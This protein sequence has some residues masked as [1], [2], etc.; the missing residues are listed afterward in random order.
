[1]KEVSA[2]SIGLF[3]CRG[4]EDDQSVLDMDALAHEFAG[5]GSVQVHDHLCLTTAQRQL[6]GS[7]QS[8]E[9][10]GVV[11]ATCS[12]GHYGNSLRRITVERLR[13]AGLNRN[14]IGFANL[15]EQVVLPHRNDPEG[16]LRKARVLIQTALERVRQSHVMEATEIAPRRSVLVIGATIGGILA[17]YRLVAKGYKVCLIDE[18]ER[19]E[20]LSKLPVE[21]LPIASLDDASRMTFCFG[22]GLADSNGW[23]GD[24]AVEIRNVQ[25]KRT[26]N[27]GAVIVAIGEDENPDLTR[28]IH[29]LLLVELGMD[30]QL[31]PLN[32][33]NLFTETREPGVFLV[34]HEE[35]DDATRMRTAAMRA[36]SAT[37]ALAALLD[38]P[39]LYHDIAITEVN[40]DLCGACG[41][42]V[43]TCAFHA[44]S[45]NTALDVATVDVRRCKAC[46][47][48][49]TACPAA[50]R[51]LITYPHHYITRAIETLAGYQRCNG[52]PKVLCLL[53]DSC[54]YPA[55]DDA[56]M[57]GCEYPAS[58]LPLNI[59]CGGRVDT[60]YLLHA[61][62][63]GFDGVFVGRCHD[64]HCRNIVGNTDMDR[65][66]ELFRASLRARRI[67]P[68]RV[69]IWGLSPNEGEQYAEQVNDFFG[70]LQDHRGGG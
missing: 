37:T 49:V 26:L 52:E 27:V 60:Q 5:E 28:R 13:A 24:F 36:D 44:A 14:R 21:D 54:G 4:H 42:C 3:F 56:G 40:P 6:L 22:H 51:D 32:P 9:L 43:K 10:E 34:K 62:K 65:R 70:Y 47:N 58:A 18:S 38:R 30:G 12:P 64:E 69:R 48:C 20:A 39:E 66:L 33:T 50:A 68:E 67:D 45:I 61:F 7:V 35:S 2:L 46:G 8:G 41:T 57:K 23:A 1:M 16:A 29:E 63:C 19:E 11:L 15:R 59:C 17:A 31:R 25:S 53:C 55:A